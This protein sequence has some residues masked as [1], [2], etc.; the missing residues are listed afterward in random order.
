MAGVRPPGSGINSKRRF[1]LPLLGRLRRAWD[2]F[3]NAGKRHTDS[4]LCRRQGPLN[5]THLGSYPARRDPHPKS[6]GQDRAI[7]SGSGP[8]RFL[9]ARPI[10]MRCIRAVSRSIVIKAE[11]VVLSCGRRIGTAEGRITDQR[12]RLI[13]HGTTTC[14]IFQN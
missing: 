1:F 13:A 12:G 3:A 14:L 8:G 9:F 7:P 6:S 11:G 10:A 4:Y 2:C 5:H